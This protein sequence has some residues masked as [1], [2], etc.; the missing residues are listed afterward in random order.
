MQKNDQSIILRKRIG[1]I[2]EKR[3]ENFSKMEL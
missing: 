2:F 1:K 3:A